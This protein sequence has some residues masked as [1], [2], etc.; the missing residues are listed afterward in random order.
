MFELVDKPF[1]NEQM[2]SEIADIVAAHDRATEMGGIL[3]TE[4]DKYFLP[5]LEELEGVKRSSYRPNHNNGLLYDWNCKFGVVKPLPGAPFG[6]A[7][8]VP[9]PGAQLPE[10]L[11]DVKA[12]A[13]VQA[14]LDYSTRTITI[15]NGETVITFPSVDV[16]LAG[17][18]AGS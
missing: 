3:V 6:T 5:R 4:Y 13:L 17:W 9:F 12:W 10:K 14:E 7:I 1:M 18:R 16:G 2:R 15:K 8:L 11:K